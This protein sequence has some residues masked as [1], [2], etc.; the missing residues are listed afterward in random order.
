[1]ATL[2]EIDQQIAQCVRMVTEEVIDIYLSDMR[3]SEID[4]LILGC[5]H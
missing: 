4:T 3:K 2:Y 5:T 1:M